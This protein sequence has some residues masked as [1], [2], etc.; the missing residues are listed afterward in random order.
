MR[1]LW[2]PQRGKR[3]DKCCF[4]RLTQHSIS[5]KDQSHVAGEGNAELE[6]GSQATFENPMLSK[7]G[8][9]FFLIHVTV[10]ACAWEC[11]CP[12]VPGAVDCP[13]SV[14]ID[15]CE[16]PRKGAGNCSRRAVWTLNWARPQTLMPAFWFGL[17]ITNTCPLKPRL[18]RL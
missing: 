3:R 13:E 6:L 17:L 8:F 9:F 15:G 18:P 14:V 4:Q 16:W 2:L 10:W 11:K 5:W 7:V 1:K 12:Q